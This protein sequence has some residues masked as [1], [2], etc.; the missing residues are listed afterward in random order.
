ML[1]K[2]EKIEEV[3]KL[4]LASGYVENAYPLSLLVV[5]KVGGGK[6]SIL[7]KF[8]LNERLLF[9]S[10]A[11]A[12]GIIK[13]FYK[14]MKEGDVNHI[15]IPDLIAP[16]SRSRSTVNTFIAFMNCLIEEGIFRVETAYLSVDEPAKVGLITSIAREDLFDR[17]HGWH[18]IG[19][20]SRLVPVSY[21]YN[22]LDIIDILEKLAVNGIR[23]VVPEVLKLENTRI[24][25]DAE[26]NKRMIPYAVAFQVAEGVYGFRRFKQLEVLMMSSAL[27]RGFGKVEEPDFM[28]VRDLLQYINLDFNPL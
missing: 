17:R 6:T 7:K 16:F 14:E 15:V 18:R 13:N 23:E 11:T 12:Y 27:L 22:Q 4:V 10:D 5:S 9:L 1:Y 25:E 21:S 28:K 24:E 20:L 2:T 3:L 26:L 8:M 19:F